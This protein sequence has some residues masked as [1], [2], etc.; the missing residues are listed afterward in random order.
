LEVDAMTNTIKLVL[1]CCSIAFWG[2]T[3]A[4]ENPDII[5][6]PIEQVASLSVLNVSD[7]NNLPDRIEID[8]LYSSKNFINI[9]SEGNSAKYEQIAAGV[10]N[11][12][13]GDYKDT[14]RLHEHNYYTLMVYDNDSVRLAWDAS[15]DNSNQFIKMPAVRWNISGDDPTNY[16]VDFSV[17]SVLKD[18]PMDKF[19]SFSADKGNFTVQLYDKASGELLGKEEFPAQVN[20][21]VT[22][23]IKRDSEIDNDRYRFHPITQLVQ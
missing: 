3:P 7:N 8:G 16:K 17:D 20:T 18:I 5:T 23:N 9:G 10:R 1:F 6:D 2:C 12:T 11:I 14:I 4:N 19:I 13:I 22:V 15:Y 21:K